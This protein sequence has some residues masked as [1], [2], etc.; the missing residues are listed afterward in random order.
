MFKSINLGGQYVQPM[1]EI[2]NRA[3]GKVQQNPTPPKQTGYGILAY[4]QGNNHT[5][6]DLE[7][8]VLSILTPMAN[9]PY[10]Q[11]A[12]VLDL[13]TDL[14]LVT[15]AL[16]VQNPHQQYGTQ[17]VNELQQVKNSIAN[18]VTQLTQPQ[19]QP[20][21][22]QFQSAPYDPYATQQ[23][24]Y[25]SQPQQVQ[26]PQASTNE[27]MTGAPSVA[28]HHSNT[29][30]TSASAPTGFETI[31]GIEDDVQPVQQ[32][33]LYQEPVT[34]DNGSILDAFTQPDWNDDG[35]FDDIDDQPAT[36]IEQ[37]DMDELSVTSPGTTECTVKHDVLENP[38]ELKLF[39]TH[40]QWL[41][42]LTGNTGSPL[43]MVAVAGSLY[44]PISRM[45]RKST[46]HLGYIAFNTV[47]DIRD[48][49]ANTELK[50]IAIKDLPMDYNTLSPNP[51]VVHTEEN[52]V[53]KPADMIDK[54]FAYHVTHETIAC[55]DDSGSAAA[56]TRCTSL[57]IS[58]GNTLADKVKT[59]A[60]N[61]LFIAWEALPIQIVEATSVEEVE[62]P[63]YE[64]DDN[65]STIVDAIVTPQLVER[66]K[67]KLSNEVNAMLTN[68]Y[69]FP[70]GAISFDNVIGAWSKLIQAVVANTDYS[71]E[72]VTEEFNRCRDKVL[73]G[74]HY[75]VVPLAD[76]SNTHPSWNSEDIESLSYTTPEEKTTYFSIEVM[77]PVAN[78][79][80]WLTIEELGLSNDERLST[81]TH[82]IIAEP[83]MAVFEKYPTL[84][85]IEVYDVDGVPTYI[86]RGLNKSRA[87]VR[88][89]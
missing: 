72:E 35:I 88:I 36:T 29:F 77:S 22:A 27:W 15:A 47:R 31:G 34:Q 33:G 55:P 14:C 69:E 43:G 50:Y 80:S 10:Q 48:T 37:T 67:V 28:P 63:E 19:Q 76:Y 24:Q 89:N 57:L 64:D 18:A 25:H 70:A 20:Q 44:V 53:H 6:L 61:G 74:S 39:D 40:K 60:K 3:S 59:R 73:R 8:K 78:L 16:R 41:E 86:H 13:L 52:I 42:L 83:I 32:G 5:A 58:V 75:R 51:I 71:T 21:Y 56:A 87:L 9:H 45:K 62:L 84:T 23:N 2:I 85:K 38:A 30:D 4:Q 1:V 79:G 65:I 81:A 11:V 12:Q 17:A 68:R 26:Q 7:N 54:E 82:N 46:C 66:I 49:K